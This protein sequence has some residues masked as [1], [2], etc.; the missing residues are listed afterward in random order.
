MLLFFCVLTILLFFFILI[1]LLSDIRLIIDDYKYS[2]FEK[3]DKNK[4]V[5]KKRIAI[6]FLGKI[7][8]VEFK[9]DNKSSIKDNWNEIIEKI[10]KSTYRN[11]E[12]KY[13]G[14]TIFRVLLNKIQIKKFVL[15]VLISTED[16]E[17]TAY[18]VGIVSAIIPLLI[19]KNIEK[20]NI[21]DYKIKIQPVYQ[22]KN[23]VSISL[24]CIFSIK[25]VHII[26][27]LK[28]LKSGKGINKDERTS[29]RRSNA[30]SYGKHKK[31]DRC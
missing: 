19:R 12:N 4:Q 28:I 1:I 16:L 6:Y 7:K 3:S 30:N 29:N 21:N 27:M 2:N 23:A 18:S 8:V 26:N 11:K 13:I 17:L 25:I 31:Y 22:N 9:I 24:S 10:N 15:S 5:G 20:I 14:G